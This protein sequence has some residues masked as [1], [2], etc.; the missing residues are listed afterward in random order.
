M[1]DVIY[2]PGANRDISAI[3]DYTIREHGA[4]Q[5]RNYLW[6]MRQSIETLRE[7]PSIGPG[8][9]GLPD[10]YRKLIVSQHRVIYHFTKNEVIIVRVIHERQ[11]VPDDLL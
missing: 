11:D 2:R 1:R 8:I 6:E 10:R 7:F 4:D 3:A 5:A 9:E